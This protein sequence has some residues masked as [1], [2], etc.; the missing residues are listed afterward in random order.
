MQKNKKIP[1]RP[2]SKIIFVCYANI[3]RSPMAEAM[4]KK[5]L[6]DN[7]FIESAGISTSE[8]KPLEEVIDFMQKAYGI[9]VSVHRSRNFKDLEMDL[10]DC[11]FVLDKT[12]YYI[13]KYNY[14]IPSD[15]LVLWEIQDPCVHGI[16]KINKS[17]NKIFKLIKNNISVG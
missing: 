10:Y 17:A 6:G 14:K 13:L 2:G 5:I 12:A 11:V 8:E 15:K 4:A 9:D 16:K 7:V 1:V 3:C